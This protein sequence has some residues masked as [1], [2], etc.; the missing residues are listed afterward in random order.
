MGW[1]DVVQNLS[2]T[3][4]YDGE[5]GPLSSCVYLI[6]KIMFTCVWVSGLTLIQVMHFDPETEWHTINRY[7]GE[8]G[9][10]L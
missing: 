3:T 6:I 2:Y 4:S 9:S 1:E 5:G 7:T 8:G 10:K